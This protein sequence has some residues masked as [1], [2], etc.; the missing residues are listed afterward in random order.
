MKLTS[1]LLLAAAILS[2]GAAFADDLVV[3]RIDHPNGPATYVTA[4]AQGRG[5]VSTDS[6]GT[7]IGVYAGSRSFRGRDEGVRGNVG[8]NDAQ[9]RTLV[10][11][12][13]GRGQTI[14]TSVQR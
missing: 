13:Q 4:P 14:Y 8:L 10:P 9:G 7:T 12:H 3:R 6:S 2:S 1:K 5:F 11:I